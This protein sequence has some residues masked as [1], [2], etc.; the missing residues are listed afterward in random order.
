MIE[1]GAVVAAVDDVPDVRPVDFAGLAARCCAEDA[2]GMPARM[3]RLAISTG[4]ERG[5][6]K[7]SQGGETPQIQ[8]LARIVEGRLGAFLR[9]DRSS[10]KTS[11]LNRGAERIFRK[12]VD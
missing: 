10:Q 11:E 12:E 9:V 1:S 6:M 2:P 8:T 7:D 5:C 4:R 3:A